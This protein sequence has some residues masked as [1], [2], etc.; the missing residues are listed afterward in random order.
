MERPR[1][2]LL[3][4]GAASAGVLVWSAGAGALP[5]SW[6]GTFEALRG[7][8]G[9][10]NGSRDHAVIWNLRLPRILMGFAAGG[11]LGLCGTAL[12]GLFR[13]PLA[14]PALIGI[15]GG[16]ALGAVAAIVIG[17]PRFLH[18][19]PMAGLYA[20]PGAAFLGAF[21]AAAGVY[22]VAAWQGRVQVATLLLAGIAIN[23]VAGAAIGWLS[24]IATD[25]QL[26]ALSFWSLGSVGGADW[27][28]LAGCAPFL[29]VALILLPRY[30]RPLNVLSLGEANARHMGAPVE[31]MKR[32]IVAASALAVGAMVSFTGTIGFIGL[33]APHLF[34]MVG[35]PDHRWVLPG[36]FLIGGC[37]LCAADVVARVAVA[38]AEIPVGIIVSTIGAPFFLFLLLREKR[39]GVD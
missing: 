35:G 15:S 17:V 8:F 10:A 5:I 3:L 38:P 19:I 18:G 24:F 39:R 34:R 28:S 14:D 20:V 4:L 32:G 36:S 7:G 33:I 21:A 6:G 2:L 1:A 13:N 9:M 30:A 16:G 31:G 11:T 26:R 23:A 22:R 25:V 37:L 27:E 29:L 12:Q